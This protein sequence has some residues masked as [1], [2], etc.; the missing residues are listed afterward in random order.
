LFQ[1]LTIPPKRKYKDDL[2]NN[3]RKEVDRAAAIA[4]A[5]SVLGRVLCPP[6]WKEKIKQYQ[7]NGV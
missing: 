6:S 1:I 7:I 2:K 4:N 3:V 5:E